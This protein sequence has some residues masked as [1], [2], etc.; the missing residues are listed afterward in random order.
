MGLQVPHSVHTEESQEGAVRTAAGP[1]WR[2]VS[3]IS[4]AQG[5]PDRGRA[6]DA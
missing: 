3:R 1:P 6:F 4:A 5:E 2:G